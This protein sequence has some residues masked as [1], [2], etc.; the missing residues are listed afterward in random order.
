MTYRPP[1]MN[2]PIV[3]RFRALDTFKF[4]ST[5]IGRIRIVKS[6]TTFMTP[7]ASTTAVKLMHLPFTE[8]SHCEAGGTH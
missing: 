3:I 2:V 8:V 7:A 4:Q 1:S 5:G 6:V